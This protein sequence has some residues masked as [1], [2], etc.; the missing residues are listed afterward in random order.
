MDYFIKLEPQIKQAQRYDGLSNE[1]AMELRKWVLL[2]KQS[3]EFKNYT[4]E[5]AKTPEQT[6]V[7]II[8]SFGKKTSNRY[9]IVYNDRTKE[10]TGSF[11]NYFNKLP[12]S[13]KKKAMR[14]NANYFGGIYKFESEDPKFFNAYL[15]ILLIIFAVISF[16]LGLIF[17]FIPIYL[18]GMAA[19]FLWNSIWYRKRSSWSYILLTPWLSWTYFIL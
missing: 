12:K 19:A 1:G 14:F 18:G 11:V 8:T 6:N 10:T 9:Q 7:F 17:V 4:F 15:I 3:I 16:F 2:M 13:I 5:I